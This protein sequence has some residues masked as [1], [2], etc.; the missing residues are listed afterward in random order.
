M[1]HIAVYG[2]TQ[3]HHK[4]Q[5]QN[6]INIIIK[7][8]PN[9]QMCSEREQYLQNRSELPRLTRAQQLN[10]LRV[11]NAFIQDLINK[12]G[13]CLEIEYFYDSSHPTPS[14]PSL[15]LAEDLLNES[16]ILLQLAYF[17]SSGD[18]YAYGVS[19]N[20]RELKWKE[21]EVLSSYWQ[22]EYYHRQH[23]NG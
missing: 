20:N 3:F 4:S 10:C 8:Q 11:Q 12:L 14:V 9:Q 5:L 1:L 23:F 2:G 16:H 7:Y 13:P 21:I 22:K 18:L 6:S 17:S 19:F 15:D